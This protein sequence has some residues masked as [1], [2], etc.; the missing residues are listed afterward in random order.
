M[1]WHERLRS[2]YEFA[3]WPDADAGA[4][5]PVDHDG[6]V[7]AEEA[8]D[9]ALQILVTGELGLRLSGDR[10]HEVGT[11]E[12]RHTDLTFTSAFQELQED[13]AGTMFAALVDDAVQRLQPFERLF[14]VAVRQ[15]GG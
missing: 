14:D 10:V 9:A 12:R 4:L 11:D 15:V 8:P 2:E 7:P 3:G 5:G 6:G 1:V 13:V